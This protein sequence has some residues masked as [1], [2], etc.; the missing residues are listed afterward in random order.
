MTTELVPVESSQ[1]QISLSPAEFQAELEQAR[2]KAQSLK[3]LIAEHSWSVK[4][5]DSEHIRIEAWITLAKGFNCT[6]Q[7][8]EGSVRVI[9]GYKQ[10]FEARAEVLYFT[11]EKTVV[12]GSA[13]AECGTDGDGFWEEKQ[14]RHSVRSM[15]QTRALS[16][17]ISSVFRWVVVLAGYSGTP[18][19][20]MPAD[21]GSLKTSEPPTD[22]QIKYL[23]SLDPKADTAGLSKVEVSKLIDK[24][25]KEKSKNKQTANYDEMAELMV[26]DAANEARR[27]EQS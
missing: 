1:G 27:E 26:E 9:P 25:V 14:P 8:V 5:G 24:L 12:I 22:A 21:G 16:K 20:D 23:K 2:A 18:F 13:E 6:A 11:G 17:A 10:A 3:A 4:I 7:V 19:E 15:A